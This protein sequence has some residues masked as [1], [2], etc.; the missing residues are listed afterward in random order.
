MDSFFLSVRILDAENALKYVA[1]IRT[2]TR[3]PVLAIK[4]RIADGQPVLF[5]EHSKDTDDFAAFRAFLGELEASGAVLEVTQHVGDHQEIVSFEKLDNMIR[6]HRDIAL[7][8][9][10]FTQLEIGAAKLT[11]V[12]W[13]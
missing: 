9:E 8:E 11:E 5:C 4:R 1:P 12:D 13:A 6:S 10:L 2:W 3:E 7:E